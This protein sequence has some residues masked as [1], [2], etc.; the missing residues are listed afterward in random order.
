[1][2]VAPQSVFRL[3]H[4]IPFD[5]DYAHTIYFRS[6][7][8][9]V[10]YMTGK[11]VKSYTQMSYIKHG[12]NGVY[13]VKVNETADNVYGCNYCMFHNMGFGTKWFYGFVVGINY[14]NNDVTE[15]SFV[16]DHWQTWLFELEVHECYVE[17]EH[18]S[19]DTVG[20]HTVEENL[21]IGDY[22]V[23]GDAVTVD[24]GSGIMVQMAY[25]TGGSMQ[26]GVFSGL[27]LQGAST[28][29]AGSIADLLTQFA[30]TPERVA[31]VSMCSGDMVAG[32][33]VQA[34]TKS[35]GITRNLSVGFRF[36]GDT[37]IPQN[38]KLYCYPYQLLTLDNY[39]GNSQ[40][41][42]WEDFT[43]G[44]GTL[45]ANFVINEMPI[46]RPSMEC[47][48]V[49]YKGITNAQN[50]G[51]MYDNFPMCPYIIDTYRAWSSQATPKMLIS[52]GS[53]I[54]V[55][56]MSGGIMGGAQSL[57]GKSMEL[58]NYAVEQSYHQIHSTSYGGTISGSGLNFNQNRVGFRLLHQ[59]IKPEY[60]RIIDNYFTRFGYRVMEYKTPNLTSRT[61][62]N[63]I[64][65]IESNIG[66]NIPQEAIDTIEN[67]LDR[68][69][70]LW[71]TLDIRNYA[72]KNRIVGE[73]NG[74]EE[75][76]E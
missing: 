26:M 5:R 62:F 12:E 17:R 65:T 72:V 20:K 13:S 6:Q 15:I 3:L 57:L 29:G 37:Y 16:V 66:G 69:I 24:C 19:D 18:V 23:S 42:R 40:T 11:V 4:D 25:D 46:P 32:S 71:H 36:N 43:N 61:S 64:K 28:A 14:V 52:T 59:T 53:E 39:N 9:Q 75:K 48:P 68:G 47:F 2:I 7:S 63:Y 34:A 73:V 50:F 41:Y 38:N 74:K 49:N 56:V 45:S 1:M 30:D 76:A 10:S 58:A 60:A 22:V 33:S 55:G 27:Y 44:S 70:T 21:P 54:V 31:M 35:M 51:V 8:A 67:S